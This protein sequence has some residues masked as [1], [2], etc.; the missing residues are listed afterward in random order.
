M[1]SALPETLYSKLASDSVFSKLDLSKGY[2]QIP[3]KE[4]DRDK[5]TF[6]TPENG[7][8]RFKVVPFGLV[9]SGASC[10]RLMHM[11]LDDI[12]NVDSY[13]DELL[14][15][16][17]NWAVHLSVLRK[18]F[19]ALRKA[20]L[21]VRPSKCVFGFEKVEFLGHEV[22]QEELHPCVDKVKKIQNASRPQNKKQLSSFLG[23]VGY[24]RRFIPNFSSK[25]S[26]LTDLTKKRCPNIL[27]WESSHQHAFDDLRS[28]L[29]SEP[30]LKLP[31]ETKEFI[32]QTDASDVAIGAALLQEHD[33]VI[34][35]VC[36]IS[37]RLQ[38]REEHYSTMEKECLAIVWSIQKL[39]MYCY[40]RKFM[41]QTDHQP[42]VYLI[43]N[44]V[45]NSRLM[46]WAM[47][48]QN[49]RFTIVSI[50]GSENV[51]GDYLS[52]LEG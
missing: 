35:P 6:V 30:I 32:V 19:E 13:V 15:H 8:F 12:E 10:N 14:A 49:Y 5:T 36:Y 37:R 28:A 22:G 17:K 9:T 34:F 26:P 51:F 50:K 42:L 45:A 11:L 52:R 43:K 24:Y 44:K 41:L 25:A 39:Q 7:M 33:G 21:T 1:P 2:W 40:G 31:D 23:L 29:A 47:Q 38:K 3:I 48:L 4:E 27:V 20:N 18:L 16:T 46:R